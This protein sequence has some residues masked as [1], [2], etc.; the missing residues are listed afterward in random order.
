M[1]E[2]LEYSAL[3]FLVYIGVRIITKGIF[4]SYFEEKETYENGKQTDSGRPEEEV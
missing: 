1:I 4:K 3:F 2:A